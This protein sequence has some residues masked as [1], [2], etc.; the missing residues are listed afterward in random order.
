MPDPEKVIRGFEC[1][2]RND[3]KKCPY[4]SADILD[5][6]CYTRLHTDALALLKEQEPMVMTLEEVVESEDWMW[7]EYTSGYCE[8][9]RQIDVCK[10]DNS[11][12][13]N[14]GYI[15]TC[16]D[17]AQRWRCWTSRPS[18]QQMRDTKWEGDSD[19]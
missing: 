17:Y 2:L 9:C 7:R 14:D 1:C 18:E 15:E 4:Y 11:I 16:D 3:H 13:W 5:T 19:A 6:T 12:V 8:W 10:L